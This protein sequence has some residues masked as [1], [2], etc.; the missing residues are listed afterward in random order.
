MPERIV[1]I[2]DKDQQQILNAVNEQEEK[3]RFEHFTNEDA[4][5]LGQHL[6]KKVK[7]DGIQM[8]VAIRK[9]N[10]NTIFAY[11]S[12]GTNLMNENWMNRKFKTVVMNESSSFKQWALNMVNNYSVESM[13]MDQK[14]Y[15]LCGGGFPIKLKNGEMVAVVLASNL[16]HQQDHMFL[17]NG[18]ASFLGKDDMPQ[19]V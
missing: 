6:A 2:K 19:I 8:A 1:N 7:D 11:F 9:L 13:G 3:L 16:P 14:D 15:V 12:E 5:E 10:G 4:W 17:V 18:I